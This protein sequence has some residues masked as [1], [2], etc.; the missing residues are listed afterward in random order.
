MRK[1]E[2]EQLD[3]RKY[4]NIFSLKHLFCDQEMID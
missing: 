4:K 1:I 3:Q 2:S